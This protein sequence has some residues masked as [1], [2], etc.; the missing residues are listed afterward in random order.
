MS[1][2][3][4]SPAFDQFLEN[5]ILYELTKDTLETTNFETKVKNLNLGKKKTTIDT[6]TLNSYRIVLSI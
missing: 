5:F 4:I 1:L 2:A 3:K 6:L